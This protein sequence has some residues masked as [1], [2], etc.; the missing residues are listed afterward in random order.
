VIKEEGGGA[1]DRAACCLL[2]AARCS[3]PGWPGAA[4]SANAHLQLSPAHRA[5]AATL[6]RVQL[7]VVLWIRAIA[8][9]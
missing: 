9:R 5:A 7:T 8:V 3:Q 1:A 6:F 2:A 4:P